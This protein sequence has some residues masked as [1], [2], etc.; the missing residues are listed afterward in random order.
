MPSP[1]QRA[2]RFSTFLQ[3]TLRHRAP[4]GITIAF[5]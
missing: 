2:R 1:I 3:T 5:R 4:A